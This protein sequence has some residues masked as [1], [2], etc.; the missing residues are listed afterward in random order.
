MP[1]CDGQ[2]GSRSSRH[3]DMPEQIRYQA[4]I[5]AGLCASCGTAKA[6][7]GKIRCRAC[8]EHI[9]A[10]NAERSAELAR[11]G[12]CTKCGAASRS[13]GR[14]YCQNCLDYFSARQRA[15]PATP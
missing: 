12:L 9:S 6:R 8:A 7:R 5:D 1:I 11:Q 10:I 2:I 4:R 15:R 14:A 3:G 13:V